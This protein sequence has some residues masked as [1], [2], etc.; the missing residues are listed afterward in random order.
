LRKISGVFTRFVADRV[1]G[2]CSRAVLTIG[3]LQCERP[4]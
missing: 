2:V 4:F 1:T 3:S